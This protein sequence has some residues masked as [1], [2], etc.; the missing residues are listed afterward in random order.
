MYSEHN[1]MTVNNDGHVMCTTVQSM[2]DIAYSLPA[3]S[4]VCCWLCCFV[5]KVKNE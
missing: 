1:N 5:V 3:I 4:D 2:N